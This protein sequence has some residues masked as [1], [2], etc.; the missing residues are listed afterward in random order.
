MKHG[1]VVVCG[2]LLISCNRQVLYVES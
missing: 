2:Y 1:I